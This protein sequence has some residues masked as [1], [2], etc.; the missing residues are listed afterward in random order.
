VLR[1]RVRHEIV[2]F[3][4]CHCACGSHFHHRG[5]AE[6]VPGAATLNVGG[7]AQVLS[8]SCASAGN[9]AAGGYY[10][11]GAENSQAF[12]ANE[13]DGAWGKAEEVPGTSK[14]NA[15]GD[16]R[17]LCLSCASTGDCVS[18][19]YYADRSS[20]AQGFVVDYRPP[21]PTVGRFSPHK[22]PT[23][24]RTIVTITGT[25]LLAPISVHFGT[26]AAK[27][28]KV[29]STTEI[30]VTSPAGTGTTDVTVTTAGGTSARVPAD[31]FTY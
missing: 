1:G 13:T 29:V 31:R 21:A 4:C 18:G 16:A 28:D 19:G 20:N 22:G 5:N 24:G 27:I 11:N 8:L 23:S 12:V 7:D 10:E 15:G 2:S 17:V 14:L 9:C 6:E 3:S 30:E 25:D 26:A